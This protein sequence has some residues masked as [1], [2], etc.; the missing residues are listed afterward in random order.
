MTA[1]LSEQRAA[2]LRADYP[3]LAIHEAGHA[4]AQWYYG[5]I[6]A[7][8]TLDSQEG[9]A[10]Y[11]NVVPSATNAD[12]IRQSMVIFAA[13]AIAEALWFD[14][15]ARPADK[16]LSD[17]RAAAVKL[18]GTLAPPEVI[19]AEITQAIDAARELVTAHLPEV[20]RVADVLVNAAHQ[21]S[22]VSFSVS[23]QPEE[24]EDD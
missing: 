15:D 24:P 11:F 10:V 12:V 13:G 9:G 22:Q 20:K 8:I 18:H 1:D 6:V 2:A 14:N 4:V 5:R 21:I 19:D 7:R 3:R 16:D 17:L 23:P